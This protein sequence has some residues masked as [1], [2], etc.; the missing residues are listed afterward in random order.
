MRTGNNVDGPAFWYE[1]MAVCTRSLFGSKNLS[2]TGL[3]PTGLRPRRPGTRHFAPGNSVLGGFDRLRL[4]LACAALLQLA[5]C[6]WTEP[7]SATSPSS[8][9]ARPVT[10]NAPDTVGGRAAGVALELLGTPYRYG[11]TTPKG[12]DC[13]G[14]VQYAYRQA[15]KA[16]PRTSRAQYSAA[17]PIN[18]SDAEPGDLLFFASGRKVDHV[19]IYLGN[20]QFV[21]APERGR[22]VETGRLADGY[23]RENFVGAGRL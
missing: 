9:S 11:G 20:G 18:L 10:L 19:A 8:T 12:F 1:D 13:S 16:V 7:Y 6:S 14:L 4:A 15:G 22:T 17:Q 3:R 21:H 5:G 2:S 23:Y